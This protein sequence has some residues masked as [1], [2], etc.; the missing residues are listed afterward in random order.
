MPTEPP[1]PEAR[2]VITGL[3]RDERSTIATD[4]PVTGVKRP[5]GSVI[6][7]LWRVEQLPTRMPDGDGL[8]GMAGLAPPRTGAVVR[9]CIFPPD[10]EMDMDAF[11]A[12]M[13]EIYGPE[14]RGAGSIPGLH[15]TETVDVLTVLSG[16]LHVVME[17]G[18]T[19]LRPGDTL[20]QRGTNHAWR[21]RSGQPATVVS[22]MLGARD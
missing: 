7:D 22:V 3:D 6:I 11:E 16:E 20:V 13:K 15:R 5:G 10:A 1:L 9:M 21:N 2:R 18:E 12:S 17:A 8:G 19:V 14:A 4:V